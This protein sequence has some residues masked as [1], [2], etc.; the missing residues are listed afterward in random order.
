MNGFIVIDKPEGI[1]SHTVVHSVRKILGI[2]KAGHT[3]TLDPF[4]TGVLPVAL[5]DATKAITFLDESIKE[6]TAAMRLGISTD[7]QDCTGNIIR[8][9]SYGHITEEIVRNSF[10]RFVGTTRQVPPM[11]S[12]L[13]RSGVPLYKL[14]RQGLDIPRESREIKIFSLTVKKIDLPSIYFMVRCSRGTY[15]RTLAS[16]IGDVLGCGAHLSSL[17]RTAS[18]IFT[19]DEAVTLEELALLNGTGCLEDKIMSP[20]RS[21]SHYKNFELTD[22]GARM[23]RNGALPDV[24]G[25][26]NVPHNSLQ[27]GERIILSCG[28]KLLAVAENLYIDRSGDRSNFRLLRVFN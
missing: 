21:L 8:E 7:T 4:A 9:G 5:G 16:D 6:Y 23:V 13:K 22:K 20:Y 2:K 25:F 28:E 24:D 19:I 26:Q 11:F 10:S 1:T 27:A 15:V 18:G 14:A 3:G 17:H 12:A